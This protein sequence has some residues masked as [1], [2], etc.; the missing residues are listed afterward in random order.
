MAILFI[1]VNVEKSHFL[2]RKVVR[3]LNL[4]N[5]IFSKGYMNFFQLILTLSEND[6]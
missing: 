2:A 3:S 1:L 5:I 4:F 6:S